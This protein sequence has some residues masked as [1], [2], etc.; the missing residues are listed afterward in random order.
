[1]DSAA[2]SF[3]HNSRLVRRLR[4]LDV[5]NFQASQEPFSERIGQLFDL[6]GTVILSEMLG[7]LSAV[8]SNPTR[9]TCEA[10]TD[11]FLK[12]RTA[13]VHYIVKRFAPGVAHGKVKLPTPAEYHA[14]CAFTDV[15][16]SAP[17]EFSNN[18]S[19][20]FEPY[21][22]F[23]VA[24]QGKLAGKI[25]HFHAQ[26]GDAISGICPELAQLATLDQVMGQALIGQH[27]KLFDVVPILI[28]KRFE[29]LFDE[30]WSELPGKPLVR[31]MER[32][33]GAGGWLS[34]FCRE[35]QEMLLSELEIRLQPTMGLIDA[36][37]EATFGPR[38]PDEPHE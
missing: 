3:L 21:W 7:D 35:M 16:A 27:R 13:L 25:H 34:V 9:G 19:A 18:H 1:M 2:H 20:A 12:G 26:I 10:I 6:S 24:L 38:L 29:K 36:L 28:G 5:V 17:L 23:Y 33:M 31:D 15:Y 14:H 11:E 22:D 30:H 37:S 32:W 4:E 8:G